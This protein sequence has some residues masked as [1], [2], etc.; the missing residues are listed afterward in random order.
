M[1]A[2]RSTEHILFVDDEENIL[3]VARE[4]FEFKGYHALT[5]RN[6][7]EAIRMLESERIDC[8]FSDINMPEM[9]GLQLAK[10]LHH[11]DNTIPVIIMT[12]Y[13]SLENTLATLKNGVVDFLIK[14]VNLEQMELALKRVLRQRRM[15]VENILL[16]KELRQK[17]KIEKLNRQLVRKV[18]ELNLLNRIM[19]EFSDVDSTADTFKRVVEMAVDVAHAHAAVFVLAN[20]NIADPFLVASAASPGFRHHPA[21]IISGGAKEL[22]ANVAR[23][24]LPMLV[25]GNGSASTLAEGCSS[26]VFVPMSIRQKG[27]GVLA[28]ANFK[29]GACF[30]EKDLYYLSFIIESASRSVE[31]LAL[32][33]NIYQ[34]LF[35]TLFA[36]VNALEA[37]DL[38]TRQHSSRVAKLSVIIGEAMG[39][40]QEDLDILHFSGHLHD[41]GK[42]GIRDDILLKSSGLTQEEYEII[43][44][45]PT[46]GANIVGQLGLWDR[47]RDIIR[48]HHEHFDG[49]GYPDGLKGQDI[50][51][52][53]RIL[54]VAD[55]YDAMASGRAYRRKMDESTVVEMIRERSG[56]HFDSSV[57]DTLIRL[58]QSG[59]IP[60]ISDH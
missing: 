52:L 34:N 12:G 30:S 1:S 29:E 55:V 33:E 38:Y 40:P 15:F 56:H 35:S 20:D 36:F 11:Q 32:Y 28:A 23:D 19:G 46:I 7:R 31:N 16:K 60:R 22:V 13:P 54:A 48:S 58:Y 14:P 5:A 26:A 43:K 3:E 9:D 45:H 47:E 17:E 41:I 18:E 50:P 49:T 10:Y 2:T 57:V 27:F 6:G 24:Q 59:K 8:V 53:S 25:P 51:M 37:R 44:T 42:I 39:C 4:Y 21:A